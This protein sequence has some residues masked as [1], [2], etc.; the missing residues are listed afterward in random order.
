M[1]VIGNHFMQLPF[2]SLLREFVAKNVNYR[3]LH[4]MKVKQKEEP[5]KRI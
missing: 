5:V 3:V 1:V 4:G 2:Y